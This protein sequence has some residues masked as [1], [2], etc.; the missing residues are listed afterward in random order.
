MGVDAIPGDRRKDRRYEQVLKVCFSYKER[1]AKKI[2][3]GVT[4]DLSGGGVRFRAENPPPDGTYVEL[5]IEWPFLLQNACELMLIVRGVIVKTTARGTILRAELTEFR[6]R[7]NRSFC[8]WERPSTNY[9]V[10]A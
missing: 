1:A 8:E 5:Q 9:N 6:T 3:S 2:G 7:G 4:L 10:A